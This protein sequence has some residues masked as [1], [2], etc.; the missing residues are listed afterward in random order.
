MWEEFWQN[1]VRNLGPVY[2]CLAIV[3]VFTT[4]IHRQ[5]DVQRKLSATYV[6]SDGG[7]NAVRVTLDAQISGRAPADSVDIRGGSIDLCATFRPGHGS[8]H[9]TR[10][11]TPLEAHMSKKY[12]KQLIIS[13]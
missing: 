7:L 11:A 5:P 12:W 10:A 2:F 6:L 4:I 9:P 8:R 13:F 3:F 1:A